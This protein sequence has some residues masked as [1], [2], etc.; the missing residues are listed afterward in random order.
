MQEPWGEV[1]LAVS[2]AWL[3]AQWL[4]RSSQ[5]EEGQEMRSE[6]LWQWIPLLM[7][8]GHQFL[9]LTVIPNF[10]CTLE[11]SGGVCKTM[12]AFVSFSRMGLRYGLS[13]ENYYFFVSP[14][15]YNSQPR[16]RPL[17]EREGK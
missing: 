3:E 8:L 5:W 14:G 4:K 11:S 2:E 15:D 9:C 16:L 13:I 7:A 10:S 17:V 6:R 1:M 12:D